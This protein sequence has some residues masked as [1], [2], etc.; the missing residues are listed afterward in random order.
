M[1]YEM[2][3]SVRGYRPRIDFL[4]TYEGEP[5]TAAVLARRERED[6]REIS[7]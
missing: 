3:I 6:G 7:R 2:V 1:T 5:R 4:N